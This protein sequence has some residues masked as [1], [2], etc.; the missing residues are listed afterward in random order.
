MGLWA[1]SRQRPRLSCRQ[2]AVCG[3]LLLAPIVVYPLPVLQKAAYVVDSVLTFYLNFVLFSNVTELILIPSLN[4]TVDF[5]CGVISFLCWSLMR[6]IGS[7]LFK[8]EPVLGLEI[9]PATLVRIQ[10]QKQGRFSTN[11]FY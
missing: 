8:V 1:L 7:V 3:S 11:H 4:H 9:S 6:D 10:G 5:W 2:R